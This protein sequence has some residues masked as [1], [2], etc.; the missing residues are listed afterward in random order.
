MCTV[1]TFAQFRASEQLLRD[2][3]EDEDAPGVSNIHRAFDK[4]FS[5]DGFPFVIGGQAGPVT[6]LHP[7]PVQIFQLWQIYIDN[8]N[9]LLKITHVPT[10][11]SQIIE[12]SSQLDK[13]PKNI[14]AL[15]FSIYLMAITSL[16]DI[17]VRNRFAEPRQVLLA[18][19][20]GGLQQAL[21]NAD[22]MRVSDPIVLQAF[23]LY[24]VGSHSP[25]F[26]PL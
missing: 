24:L 3:S 11:Q 22:F 16:E 26:G 21:I 20:H 14:E 15:M 12:A 1:L 18:R 7:P 5:N 9:K 10:I 4:M 6:D 8:I 17:D 2:S 19:Y 25:L 23:V 13:V